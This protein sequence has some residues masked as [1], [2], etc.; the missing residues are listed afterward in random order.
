M[1]FQSPHT[2]EMTLAFEIKHLL[3]LR[4]QYRG[5]GGM[6]T[7]GTRALAVISQRAHDVLITALLLHFD[8]IMTLFL[9]HMSAWLVLD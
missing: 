8:V 6:A 9:R 2:N 7:Q 5:G 3:V 1:D 4:S